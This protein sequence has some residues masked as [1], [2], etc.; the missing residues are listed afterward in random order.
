MALWAKGIADPDIKIRRYLCPECGQ[1]S[2]H[3]KY[4]SFAECEHGCFITNPEAIDQIIDNK[5]YNGKFTEEELNYNF[6]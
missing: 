6:I 5:D 2:L 3:I 4:E 1:Y